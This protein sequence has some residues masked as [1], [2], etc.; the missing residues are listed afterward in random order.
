MFASLRQAVKLVFDP[1]FTGVVF[2]AIVLTILLFVVAQALSE[3]ALSLLPVLSNP[4]VNKAL[5]WLT[6]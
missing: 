5:Q 2:K 4:F 3:Y 1:A 6:N